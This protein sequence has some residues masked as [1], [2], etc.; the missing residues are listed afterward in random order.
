MTSCI[1]VVDAEEDEGDD[2]DGSNDCP[3]A[4]STTVYFQA[5]GWHMLRL[6]ERSP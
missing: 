6:N 2:D 4:L 1:V 3:L 5:K